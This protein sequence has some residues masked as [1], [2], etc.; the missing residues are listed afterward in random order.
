MLFIGLSSF[1]TRL[2]IIIFD[3]IDFPIVIRKKKRVKIFFRREKKLSIVTSSPRFFTFP[4]LESISKAKRSKQ[5]KSSRVVCLRHLHKDSRERERER[6]C[7]FLS[8]DENRDIRNYIKKKRT[9][10][11]EEVPFRK[12]AEPTDSSREIT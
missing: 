6:E 2:V 3:S 11:D 5:R 7:V 4:K 10:E 9:A 8:E 1:P 12:R